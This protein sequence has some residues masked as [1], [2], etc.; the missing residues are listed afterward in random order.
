LNSL[1]ATKFYYSSFILCFWFI[2]A[3]N[4]LLMH[5]LLNLHI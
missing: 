4:I 5:A 3:D 2:K 1:K